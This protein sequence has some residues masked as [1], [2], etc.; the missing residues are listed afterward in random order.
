MN[1]DV[2]TPDSSPSPTPAF[3]ILTEA[4]TR[5]LRR[6]FR[7]FYLVQRAY[8]QM[9]S[10]SDVLSAVWRDLRTMMRLLL[11]WATRSYRRIS[12]TPLVLIVGA[13]LY[14]VVPVD[15][16]PDPLGAIGFIDDVTVIST[17]VGRVRHELER[18][19]DWE[20]ARALPE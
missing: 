20:Q 9:L 17:V 8:R 14:F 6:R 1:A 13:L 11:R 5:V 15:V 7:V 18:F 16:V 2:P 10:H 19:R 4:A 12:W 3:R